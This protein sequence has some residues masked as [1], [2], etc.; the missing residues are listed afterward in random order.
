LCIFTHSY[1][2]IRVCVCMHWCVCYLETR[3]VTYESQL[4][5]GVFG[6]CDSELCADGGWQKISSTNVPVGPITFLQMSCVYV[7]VS[8]CV[9]MCMCVFVCVCVCV[10]VSTC[11][12]V[13]VYACVCVSTGDLH[14]PILNIDSCYTQQLVTG[15][16]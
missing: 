9:C 3:R 10:C 8:V 12:C 1:H 4:R 6:V 2:H 13:F 14:A 5:C 7:C 15:S 11:Q 16:N